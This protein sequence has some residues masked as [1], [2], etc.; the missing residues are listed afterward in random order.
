MRATRAASGTEQDFLRAIAQYLVQHV[1]DRL[2]LSVDGKVDELGGESIGEVLLTPHRSYFQSVYP[3]IAKGAIK[4]IAHITGGG[5]TDNL[6]RVLPEGTAA[7]IQRSAWEVP[8]LFQWLQRAGE[9]PAEDM[10]RT[11]NMGIGLILVCTP[12]L[13]DAVMDDLRARKEAPVA[14]GD[15]VAGERRVIY[16]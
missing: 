7:R 13:A 11:F 5:I 6:P 15:I 2:G 9:V 1:F 12:A 4:G 16:A 14:M 10:L 3:L 8:A